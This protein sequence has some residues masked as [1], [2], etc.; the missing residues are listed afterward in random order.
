MKNIDDSKSSNVENE[1]KKQ[2]NVDEDQKIC[3]NAEFSSINNDIQLNDTTTEIEKL[4]LKFTNA[5]NVK[6][7]D[8]PKMFSEDITKKSKMDANELIDIQTHKIHMLA[9][10]LTRIDGTYLIRQSVDVYLVLNSK[11]SFNLCN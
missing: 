6:S 8:Y 2:S 1:G 9:L 10:N 4:E 3:S 5:E 11:F 7:I